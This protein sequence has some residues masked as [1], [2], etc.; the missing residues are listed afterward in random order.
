MR[1]Q[2]LTFRLNILKEPLQ[3]QLAGESPVI[4]INMGLRSGGLITV[5]DIVYIS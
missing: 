3:I 4:G 2:Y 1:N 5:G